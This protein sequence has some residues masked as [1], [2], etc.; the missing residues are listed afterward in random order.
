MLHRTAPPP[1]AMAALPV[2]RTHA[3]TPR[4]ELSRWFCSPDCLCV[5]LSLCPWLVPVHL[6][7]CL[8]LS[9]L[10][11]V[12]LPVCLV[13]CMFVCLSI[14]LN[15]GTFRFQRTVL[16]G[17]KASWQLQ[18]YVLDKTF[19]LS[20]L[21][22]SVDQTPVMHISRNITMLPCATLVVCTSLKRFLH[23]GCSGFHSK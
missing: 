3:G 5:S 19:K 11:S 20:L 2:S 16:G 21:V 8:C 10:L 6:S 4:S 22:I 14:Y 15:N 12:W 18:S 9:V 13:V 7:V 23:Q 1:P 17:G